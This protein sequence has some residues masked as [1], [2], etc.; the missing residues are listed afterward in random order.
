M[1][2]DEKVASYDAKLAQIRRQS[3]ECRRL[4]KISGVGVLSA[5]A[6]VA[7]VGDAKSFR[8]IKEMVAVELK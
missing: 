6:L 1:D 8:R 7:A 4:M 5:T 3:E 2:L